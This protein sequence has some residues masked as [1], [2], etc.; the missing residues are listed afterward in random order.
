MNETKSEAEA[1]A[2]L[3][4]NGCRKPIETTYAGRPVIFLPKGENWDVYSK[5]DDAILDRPLRQSGVKEL[6]DAISL[7]ALINE[8]PQAPAVIEY[9][10]KR[11]EIGVIFNPGTQDATGWADHRAIYNAVAS[12]DLTKWRNAATSLMTHE[13]LADFLEDAPGIIDPAKADLL[14]VVSEFRTVETGSGKSSFDSRTGS[15]TIRWEGGQKHE[16][17]I[18]QLRVRVEAFRHEEPV[19]ELAVKLRPVVKEKMVFFKIMINDFEGAFDAAFEK[20]VMV[21]TE[22]DYK[23]GAHDRAFH[24]A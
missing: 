17:E 21:V 1:V 20:V 8:W 16:T 4:V 23:N 7:A 6:A 18:P 5:G 14:T 22:A 10:L 19:I 12:D 2:E 11:K 9:S 15:Y 3:A 24:I 13:G